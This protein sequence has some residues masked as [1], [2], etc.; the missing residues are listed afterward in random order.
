MIA[1]NRQITEVE[2]L[3][4]DWYERVYSA[5]EKLDHGINQIAKDQLKAKEE[6][7]A[8]SKSEDDVVEKRLSARIEELSIKL[9]GKEST[10]I[11]G[12]RWL[13]TL[14]V[15]ICL[16][17]FGVIGGYFITTAIL[18]T[19]LGSLEKSV[20]ELNNW[21]NQ[22]HEKISVAVTAAQRNTEELKQLREDLRLHTYG[23]KATWSNKSKKDDSGE[24]TGE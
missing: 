7:K 5:I 22:N 1:D 11:T 16:S 19:K 3:R 9:D 21:K 4:K 18:S 23:S 24:Y 2:S 17:F 14:I 6:I 8:Y 15:T 10:N 20:T 12:R 13:I